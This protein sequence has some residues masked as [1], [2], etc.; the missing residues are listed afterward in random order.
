M[1]NKYETFPF[2]NR[3]L[4]KN[5]LNVRKT[6]VHLDFV[7]DESDFHLEIRELIKIILPRK[8]KGEFLKKLYSSG[9]IK[10]ETQNVYGK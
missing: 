2:T 8:L 4:Q 10:D 3:N 6:Q 7:C 5:F 1:N 9:S